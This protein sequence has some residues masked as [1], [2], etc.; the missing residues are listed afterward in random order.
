[1]EPKYGIMPSFVEMMDRVLAE[2]LAEPDVKQ[3]VRTSVS[4]PSPA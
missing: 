4:A 3:P 1:M 2:V